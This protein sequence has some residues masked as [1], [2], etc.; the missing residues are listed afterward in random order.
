MNKTI[1]I[2]LLAVFSGIYTQ[3]QRYI[4]RQGEIMFFSYTK[5][6][7]IKAVNNNV[8]SVFDVNTGEIEVR[9]LMNA[10]VFEKSLMREHF[11][12]SYIE[13]DRFPRAVFEGKIIDFDPTIEEEQIRWIKGNFV[14]HGVTKEIEIKARITKNRNTYVFN[15]ELQLSVKNY[16]IKIP[17]LLSP[18][19]SEF[20]KVDFNLEFEPYEK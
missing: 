6:E 18:N 17:P 15:G 13:S 12:E 8:Q 7:N 20:I 19:I 5:V 16:D 10:F 3:N 14:L 2:L 1:I 11:N 9:M 4:S